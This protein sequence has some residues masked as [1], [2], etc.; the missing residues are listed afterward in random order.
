MKGR[1]K[2]PGKSVFVRAHV[3]YNESVP[4]Q[5]QEE[6]KGRRRQKAL[7]VSQKLLVGGK[8]K[9]YIEIDF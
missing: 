2:S 4:G 3:C 9:Q 1:A 7:L 8:K 6:R 5:N